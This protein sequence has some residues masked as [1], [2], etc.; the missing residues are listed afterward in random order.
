MQIKKHFLVPP[1][2]S[3]SEGQGNPAVVLIHG[4]CEDHRVWDGFIGPLAQAHRVLAVDLPGFG[5]SPLLESPQR[6]AYMAEALRATLAAQE[7]ERP[8][9][10]GH[11]LGGYVALAYARQYA[12]ELAGL[13]LFHSSALPDSD[14]RQVARD[15]VAADVR[16]NGPLGF[17]RT[18]VPGLFAPETRAQHR[19][20]ID[21]L[22]DEGRK[23]DPEAVAQTAEAMRDRP[24]SRD[25]LQALAVPVLWVVGQADPVIPLEASLAQ[26]ALARDSTVHLLGGVGHMGMYEAP[27]RTLR[28]VA[29]FCAAVK[30]TG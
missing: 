7:V 5:R 6:I 18:L 2:F 27:D 12:G 1:L 23:L 19:P 25:V 8:I 14:E 28:A 26:V 17:V 24:D 9:L 10:V 11:S 20:T 3:Q 22:V 30:N 15:R 4:F 29:D 16:T 21:W 13:G